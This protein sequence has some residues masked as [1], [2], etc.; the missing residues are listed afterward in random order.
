MALSSA[1]L[2][3][4][5]PS[6]DLERSQQFYESVLGLTVVEVTPFAC[7]LRSGDTTLR[8]AVAVNMRPQPFTVLGWTVADIRVELGQLLDRGVEALRFDGM[9]QDDEGIWTAP[10]GAQVA[11]FHDPDDN[12]LSLTQLP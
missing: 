8:V 4:F 1:E 11:W 7:V 2:M 5:V 9:G 6:S 3:A 12:V 10:G